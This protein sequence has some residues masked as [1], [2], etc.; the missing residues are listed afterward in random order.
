MKRKLIVVLSTVFL[1]MVALAVGILSRVG[2]AAKRK[3]AAVVPPV[4]IAGVQ[5]RAPNTVETE[6]CVE[7][8]DAKSQTFLW[9]KKIYST[10]KIPFI[11]E[12]DNQWVFIKS[13]VPSKGGDEVI[14]VNEAG[15]Q[16]T[17][18]TTPP[19][20]FG[21]LLKIGGLILWFA[22]VYG[23]F[24]FWRKRRTRGAQAA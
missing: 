2:G 18:K 11:F 7:A 10:L 24:Q 21:F 6:G 17:V 23:V 12:E 22:I 16:Y 3:R 5:Y 15:R 20:K 4:E 1:C 19:N 13:M 9:R 14:I 8:W